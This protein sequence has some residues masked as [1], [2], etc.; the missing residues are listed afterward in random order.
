MYTHSPRQQVP[1]A[2]WLTSDYTS[3]TECQDWTKLRSKNFPTYPWNIPKRLPTKSLWRN[4]FHLVVWG[5]M[6]YALGVWWGSLRSEKNQQ[7]SATF[8]GSRI[9]NGAKLYLFFQVI[10]VERLP[11]IGRFNRELLFLID[12]FLNERWLETTICYDSIYSP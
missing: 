2:P 8:L 5:F 1:A 7:L 4:F 12:I 9:W 10:F 11:T 3:S 6:G